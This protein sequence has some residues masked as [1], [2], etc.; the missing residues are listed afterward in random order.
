MIAD[1]VKTL[2]RCRGTLLQD[3]AGVA[4]L[5]VLLL[6]ALHLPGGA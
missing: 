1:I 5:T 3:A 4:L 2:D 6:A